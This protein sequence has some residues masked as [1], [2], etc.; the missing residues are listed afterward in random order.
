MGTAP[1][2]TGPAP[3]LRR[4]QGYCGRRDARPGGRG[5]RRRVRRLERVVRHRS[6]AGRGAARQHRRLPVGR[7]RPAGR[8][9]LEAR[10]TLGK[11]PALDGKI[12]TDSE[13]SLRESL[14]DRFQDAGAC[15]DL[16]WA[17]DVDPWLGDRFAAPPSTSARGRRRRAASRPCSW[18]RWD[19][20]LAEEG[21]GALLDCAASEMGEERGFGWSI[22]AAGGRCSPRPRPRRGG[23]R[24]CGRAPLSDDDDFQRWTGAAGDHGVLTAYA[25]PEAGEL[26]GRGGRRVDGGRGRV[27]RR[28]PPRDDR[29]RAT[30]VRAATRPSGSWG[31]TSRTSRA[32]ASRCASPTA[33]SSSRPPQ[34]RPARRRGRRHADRVRGRRRRRQHAARRH[35]GGARRRLR[36]GLGR[37]APRVV[38]LAPRRPGRHRRAPGDGR[39]RDRTRPPRRRRDTVRRVRRARSRARDRPG[40]RGPHRRRRRDEDQGRLRRG[41]R[42]ARQAGRP[43]GGGRG[44]RRGAR[45]RRRGQPRGG[46]PQQRLPRGRARPGQPRP[47]RQV[48][49]RRPRVRPRRHGALPRRR[50]L[51]RPAESEAGG[52]GATRRSSRTSRCS[53]RSATPPEPTTTSPTPW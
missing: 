17:D 47:E 49:G 36:A 46:R 45:L 38:R 53:P 21:L 22:A 6:P 18:C 43:P 28:E 44:P 10:E 51:R 24:R 41:R 34:R 14:F 40:C 20:D 27:L 26:L 4:P 23:H 1:R 39:G 50:R 5:G 31:A 42:R 12:D 2:S 7:P 37:G 3:S 8:Q 13:G 9:K 52:G 11:F 30:T 19:A 35:H 29:C 16:D 48:R 15:P 25:S 33:A 32:Q